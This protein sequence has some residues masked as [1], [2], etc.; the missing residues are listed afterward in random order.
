MFLALPLPAFAEAA[1]A[2]A[3]ATQLVAASSIPALP[4]FF[5]MLRPVRAGHWKWLLLHV[6]VAGAE[7]RHTRQGCRHPCVS[8]AFRLSQPFCTRPPDIWGS[9]P[10]GVL[11]LSSSS[12]I[13]SAASK[14]PFDGLLCRRSLAPLV[15]QMHA[16]LSCANALSASA[17]ADHAGADD[18][19]SVSGW[20]VMLNG[21]MISWAS[22][23]QQVTAVSST[24][25][26]F[27]AVSQCA[28]ECVYLRIRWRVVEGSG[29]GLRT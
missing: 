15:K 6:W 3:T 16:K 2:C 14:T 29:P 5:R 27:Y 8:A 4:A 9:V 18:R 28:I 25:S 22:K 23:R 13:F 19:Q 20:S 26:E 1:F 21:A 10:L 7:P 11:L 24:E 17:D 12:Q